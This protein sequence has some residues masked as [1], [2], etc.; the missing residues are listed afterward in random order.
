MISR[1]R[2]ETFVDAELTILPVGSDNLDSGQPGE[3]QGY[4]GRTKRNRAG[5]IARAA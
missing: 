2:A 3:E 5:G 4:G 1:A